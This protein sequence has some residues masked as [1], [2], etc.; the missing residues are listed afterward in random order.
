MQGFRLHPLKA[1]QRLGFACVS[2]ALDI[3]QA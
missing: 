1:V 3:A 2:G